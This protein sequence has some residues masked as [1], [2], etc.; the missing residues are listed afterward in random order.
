MQSFLLLPSD[1][2][3]LALPR[4][5]RVKAGYSPLFTAYCFWNR[6]FLLRLSTFNS[7]L[8]LMAEI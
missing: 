5:S 2:W 3:S 4:R 6:C 8:L 1:I 7:Q